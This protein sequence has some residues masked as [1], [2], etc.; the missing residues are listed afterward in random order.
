M[1]LPKSQTPER[2]HPRIQEQESDGSHKQH[3]KNQGKSK[4]EIISQNLA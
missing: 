3:G 2:K 1:S 4:S